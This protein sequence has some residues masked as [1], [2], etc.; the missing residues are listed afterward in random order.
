MA[1]DNFLKM[2]GPREQP[3][4]AGG[5]AAPAPEASGG[6]GGGM[7]GGL[8]RF[9]DSHPGFLMG[10]GNLI[11]GRDINPA[12]LYAM[13]V[14]KERDAKAEKLSERNKTRDY[15]VKGLGMSPEQAD[16]VISSGQVGNYL[17]P[18]KDQGDVQYGL[19]PI[20][21]QDANGNDA[22]GVLGNDGS[23]KPVDTGGFQV[24]GGIEKIDAG[25]RWVLR[26][27]RTGTIVGEEPK[28][29]R[30]AE[31]EKEIGT[32]EGKQAASAPADYQAGQNALDLADKIATSPALE[33]GTGF[34]SKIWN[35]IPGTA[36]Y[37]FQ[38]MVEQAKSGAF[39][40]AIQQMRGLGSL[41]NAEGGAATAAV[42]RMNTATSKEEFLAALNDYRKIVEQGMA[43]AQRRGAQGGVSMPGVVSGPANTTSGGVQW[44]IEP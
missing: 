44:S 3:P 20:W 9:N 16:V 30:G 12:I 8:S 18:P 29:L 1:F 14:K 19:N 28:D 23:F 35:S 25:T 22:L 31:R 42:T 26:D 34:S 10:A 39:L 13:G 36:E 6:L 33:S 37:D 7:F 5:L 11:Q 21:G 15:L 41:S 24:S 4:E 43:N 27:R 17:K 40:T 38:N 2:F 32:N